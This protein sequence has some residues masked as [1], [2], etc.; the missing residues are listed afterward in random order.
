MYPINFIAVEAKHFPNDYSQNHVL[1]DNYF[2]GNYTLFY[3]DLANWNHDD[4]TKTEYY[5]E[6]WNLA[7]EKQ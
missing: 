1:P 3:T 5:T 2:N 4:N 6:A 7:F